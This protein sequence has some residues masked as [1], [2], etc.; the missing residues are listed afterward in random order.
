MAA[1]RASSTPIAPNDSAEH[2]E[3]NRRI[4][5]HAGAS[6]R[7]HAQCAAEVKLTREGPRVGEVRLRRVARAAGSRFAREGD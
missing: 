3:L 6:A 1:G 4:E 5:S 2:R 7:R